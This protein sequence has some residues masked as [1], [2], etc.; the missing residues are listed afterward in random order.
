MGFIHSAEADIMRNNVLI[1]VSMADSAARHG[2]PKY[3]FSSSV[4][5]YRDMFPGEPELTEEG[6]YPAQ[7]D[8]EYG[9]EKLYSERTAMA[10]GRTFGMDVRIARSKIAMVRL[11][12]GR[13]D[14]KRLRP[15]YAVR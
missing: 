2:V 6:A 9:W 12:L 1:N 14:E 13:A 11:A 10:Y 3:F 5:V 15:R 8:N 4:C 7:P